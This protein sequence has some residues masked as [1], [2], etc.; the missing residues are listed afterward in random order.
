MNEDP[1]IEAIECAE[2]AIALCDLGG[3]KTAAAHLQMGV[4]M[5]CAEIDARDGGAVSEPP[6]DRPDSAA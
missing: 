3:A 5:L 1:L 2:R 4:D 6:R